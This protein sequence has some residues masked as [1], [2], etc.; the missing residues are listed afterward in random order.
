[1]PV[2]LPRG[3]ARLA[4]RPSLTGS[5][6]T[7]KMIGIVV[8]AALA[9]SAPAVEAVAMTATRRRTKSAMRAGR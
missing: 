3:R 5:S 4:T 6:M 9:A 2:A 1:M 7:P 8:V